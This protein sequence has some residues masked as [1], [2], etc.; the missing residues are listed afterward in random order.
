MRC[1]EVRCDEVR[2]DEVRCE[3]RTNVLPVLLE[4]NK[5][6]IHCGSQE[7]LSNKNIIYK[8]NIFLGNRTPHLDM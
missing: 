3:T 7:M 6:S 2:C 5:S 1:D 4:T 8:F